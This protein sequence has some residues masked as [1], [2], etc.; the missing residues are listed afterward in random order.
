MVVANRVSIICPE[1]VMATLLEVARHALEGV[2]VLVAFATTGLL[3]AGLI[4]SR[5]AAGH[6]PRQLD[7]ESGRE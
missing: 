4:Y 5:N 1:G 6:D 7:P 2:E 3:G